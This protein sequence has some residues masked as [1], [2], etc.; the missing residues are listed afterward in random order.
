MPD[1]KNGKIY[2]LRSYKTD[3]IYIGS[4]TQSLSQRL[5]GHK[6]DYKKWLNKKGRWCSSFEIIKQ[7][8][9]Y[10]ELIEYADCKTKAELHKKEG[11]TIRKLNCVNK[12]K[13]V[14]GKTIEET[15]Q[16]RKKWKEDNKEQIKIKNK[17]Y[18]IT[19]RKE[20]YEYNKKWRQENREKYLKGRKN[21]R[22]KIKW[23]KRFNEV[24]KEIK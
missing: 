4:T 22:E 13:Y 3:N 17:E 7:E 20:R 5:G 2:A 10:I 1:Y 14:E 11:E 16:Y 12:I 19:K 6:R 24:L 8:D 18:R 21:Y 15:K 23:K 9:Y